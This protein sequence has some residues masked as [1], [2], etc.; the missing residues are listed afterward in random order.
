MDGDLPLGRR[1]AVFR[2]LRG[3]TQEGLALRLNRSISWVTKVERGERR[4]DSMSVLLELSR[5]LS[6]PVHQLAGNEDRHRNPG[7]ADEGMLR[8]RRVLDRSAG[9]EPRADRPTRP[10]GSLTEEASSLRRLYN[11]SDRGFSAS[12]PLLGDLIVE[13][14]AA[15]SH[16]DES[17]RLLAQTALANL[18][19]LASLELRRQG[20]YGRA[21]LAVD[22]ALLTAEGAGDELLVASVSATLTVQLMMQG[23]PEDAVALALDAVD[24]VRRGVTARHDRASHS[25]IQGALRL[26][27]AQA[28]ARA[29]DAFD[30]EA[31]LK[32]AVDIAAE[33]GRDR[34][35]HCLI[36]GPTNVQIQTV[37]M[38]VDLQRPRDAVA[39]AAGLRA[40][41]AG[42]VSR[43]CYH[44]IHVARAHGMLGN[45]D[46]MLDSLTAAYHIAP[47]FVCHDPLARD[48][49][50]DLVRRKR[51]I[52]ERLR[53]LA[54]AMR[55]LD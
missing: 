39:K 32:I 5:A 38:L 35:R 10:V 44:H 46:A 25:V 30:A 4:V 13:A 40:D 52:D 17:E 33:S 53:C 18:Y 22:R 50:R 6:V 2:K 21:R 34:E 31:M 54:N 29:G 28:A 42:S 51:S 1:I 48:Q 45:D 41:R 55:V 20:D 47:R 27:A 16:G 49:V 3:W 26:Y 12:V 36:F 43:S 15:S 23:D 11:T 14:R 8:L 7:A 9:I 19:R 24:M 37:G